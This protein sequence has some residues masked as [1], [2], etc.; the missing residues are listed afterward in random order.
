MSDVPNWFWNAIETPVK[1]GQVSVRDC[2]VHFQSW[3]E[4]G[5][6]G[7]LFVHGHNA[8][9]HWWDFIAPFF[10]SHFHT[11]ALDLSG[12][13][14]SHHRDEY[15]SGTYAEE[16]VA[17]MDA[18]SM[19][20]D[21]VVVAHSFGGA[22][23][24]EAVANYNHRVGALVLVDAGVRH[25]E[26]LK[27]REANQEPERLPRSKVYPEREVAVARFRLQPPQQ[28]DN[29]YIVDHIAR[30]SVEYDD[31]GWGWKFDEEQSLRM[32]YESDPEESL[33][34]IEVPIALIFGADSASFSRRSADYMQALKPGMRLFE[35]ADA[36]HHVF[37]D[38]P[39]E[40]VR[41]LGSILNDWG[42]DVPGDDV[43]IPDR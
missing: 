1:E 6:P 12:M 13:G 35:V 2:D 38:Q 19:P 14:N 30:H 37:L 7:L 11:A 22:M 17:V 20:T 8:H 25:P 41:V 29:Q 3:S 42:R 9:A 43:L 39:I 40:F 10:I 31:G 23:A 21:T 27:E 16:I 15:D 26:D 33:A 36:Q 24:L 28:C 18:L 5:Q 4:P 32:T 34:R